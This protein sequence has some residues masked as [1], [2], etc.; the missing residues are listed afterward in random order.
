MDTVYS[1]RSMY[2]WLV[3]VRVNCGTPRSSHE[4]P[5][6]AEFVRVPSPCVKTY[7]VGMNLTCTG[8]P[9]NSPDTTWTLDGA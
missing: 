3:S 5:V 4:R 1:P 9:N 6:E 8:C 7:P 2:T